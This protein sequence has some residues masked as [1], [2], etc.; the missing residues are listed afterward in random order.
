MLFGIVPRI[1]ELKI[2]SIW[3]FPAHEAF[4]QHRMLQLKLVRPSDVLVSSDIYRSTSVVRPSWNWL[5]LNATLVWCASRITQWFIIRSAHIFYLHSV[6][7]FWFY[8]LTMTV[9]N[10]FIRWQFYVIVRCSNSKTSTWNGF[11]IKTCKKL[12]FCIA[13]I[14]TLFM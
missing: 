14:E 10:D 11:R 7:F 3:D 6:S 5:P 8:F 1:T 4:D 13:F 2:K 12:I 9:A